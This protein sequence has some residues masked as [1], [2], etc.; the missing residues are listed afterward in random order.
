M[1]RANEVPA[2]ADLIEK[3]RGLVPLLREHARETERNR[4][5]RAE[6]HRYFQ[7]LGFYKVFQPKRYGG[8]EMPISMLVEIGAELGRG[9]GSSAWIFTNLATQSWIIGM[10]DPAAQDEVWGEAPARC[11]RPL[12]PPKEGAAGTS[13]E[14]SFSMAS[15]AS[16][17]GSTSSIGKTSRS[18]FRRREDLRTI[19]L[20]WC[21][22]AISKSTTI[23]SY[24]VFPAREANRSSSR[25]YSC[26]ATAC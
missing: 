13:T 21:Q 4:I 16:Q 6:T 15:G 19:G 22:N 8:Y 2:K 9:C 25:M 20:F 10:H 11:V 12:F 18:S 26:R 23:G 14:E 5:V 3:A 7:E 24:L 1:A 17:A